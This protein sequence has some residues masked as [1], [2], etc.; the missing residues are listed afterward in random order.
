[1]SKVVLIGC[2][3]VG[4]SYAYSLVNQKNR[5]SE[6][7][8]CDINTEKCEGEAL[9]L[10][11]AVSFAPTKMKIYAGSYSDCQNADI[12]C[13]CAGRNQNQ[14]ETR[15]DLVKKNY[16]VFKS[17]ITEINKT[18]FNGIYLIATNPLD[19]MT[20]IT[21]KLSG[22]EKNKV[23]GSGTILDT[24][25]LRFLI[26]EKLGINPKSIHGFVIGEHG[27]SEFIPW[28]NTQI[29]L[30][31]ASKFLTKNDMSKIT[32]DVRNSAYDIINK[33]GNT[34]YGIGICLAKITNAILEDSHKIFTVSSFNKEF[35]LYIGMP[36]VLGKNGVEKVLELN[37]SKED[38]LKFEESVHAIQSVLNKINL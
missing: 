38:D 12:V 15:L 1:M 14:G 37:L 19:V 16:E 6:L 25:R 30:D 18:N 22:F 23:I 33:K 13:I 21:Q 5:V 11:H 26:S 24:A 17:I 28:G 20:Q 34:S 32:Y 4:M 2:G 9:D 36:S 27:D 29:G 8:L 35:G 7:V 10:M 31:K 3:N